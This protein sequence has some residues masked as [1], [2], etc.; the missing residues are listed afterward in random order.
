MN[1]LSLSTFREAAA[2]PV[3]R[4][5]VPAGVVIRTAEFADLDRIEALQ[6]LSIAE[7]GSGYYSALEIESFLRFM[8]M[9]DRYLIADR[10]YFVAEAE[11]RIV[12]CGG[13]SRRAPGYSG[14]I[15]NPHDPA[16]PPRVRAMYVHPRAARRGIGRALLA[17]VEH[18]IAGAGCEEVS[19][20]AI[21]PGVPLYERCGYERV[22][23]TCVDFPN[24]IRLAV[25]SMHKRLECSSVAAP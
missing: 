14:A 24:G 3:M 13:W 10:T 11:S 6:R 15:G 9:M 12:G 8:P 22:G 21:L 2:P 7:L 23:D 19:L 16:A 1:V 17:A 4:D 5:S 18:A 20:D 25:V